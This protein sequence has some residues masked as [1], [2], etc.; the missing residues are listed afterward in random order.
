MLEH[1]KKQPKL[2]VMNGTEN[3]DHTHDASAG[4][5][6]AKTYDEA[7]PTT[8]MFLDGLFIILGV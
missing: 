1:D 7:Y 4:R 8:F 3:G 2:Y 5:Q 6:K